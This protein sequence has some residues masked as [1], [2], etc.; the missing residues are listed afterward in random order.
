VYDLRCIAEPVEG[1]P[2]QPLHLT[3]RACRVYTIECGP[4]N[5]STFGGRAIHFDIRRADNKVL[6][7]GRTDKSARGSTVFN[8]R[9]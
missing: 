4:I 8:S 6:R 9:T 2:N 7:G 3:R 1:K 5:L